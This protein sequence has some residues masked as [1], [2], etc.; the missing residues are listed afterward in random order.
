MVLKNLTT[1][2]EFS[3]PCNKWLSNDDDGGHS[4]IREVPLNTAGERG[5]QGSL[6]VY[7]YIWIHVYT[8]L[9]KLI[10]TH[11]YIGLHETCGA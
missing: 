4:V 2:K 3:F 7:Y 9:H 11:Q 8:L 1:L 10:A 5:Q 6:Q